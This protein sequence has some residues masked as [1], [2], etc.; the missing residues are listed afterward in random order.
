MGIDRTMSKKAW[1]KLDGILWK[2]HRRAEGNKDMETL[3]ESDRAIQ[4][5]RNLSQERLM[6]EDKAERNSK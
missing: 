4:L 3:K 2:I 6:E 5:L 1:E